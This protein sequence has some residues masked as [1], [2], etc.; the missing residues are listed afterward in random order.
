MKLN[1]LILLACLL[2]SVEGIGQVYTDKVVGKKNEEVRDSLKASEYPYTLP[3]WGKKVTKLGYDL[4]YSA[5]INL[6]YFWQESEL[7]LNN[8]NVGFNNGPMY[9]VDEIIRFNKSTA[10]A[11]AINIR[12][13]IWLFPFLNVYAILGKAKTST[14]INAGVWVPGADNSWSE[15]TSFSTKANFDA[16]MFGIGMTPTFGVGGGFIAIDMNMAWTDVSALD[17]PVFTTVIGPRLG[18]S[19]KFK[20][21]ERNI[22]VWVGG[23]R[24]SFSSD[25]KGSINLSEVVPIDGLQAKVDAGIDKVENKQIEVDNWWGSLSSAEQKNPVNIAKYNTANRALGA[26][27]NFFNSMDAALN[28]GNEAT[29][30][31]SLEKNLKQKWNFIVGSQFQ[32]NKHFMLRMEYGF[33]GARTQFLTGIQYRFGL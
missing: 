29:V 31:Y 21:P 28:D 14:E 15:V 30:Q 11:N 25:T 8:L 10:A 18:K 6:N 27:G 4:P 20:K 32:L 33:L 3:I 7:I 17:K 26:A 24:V 22:A 23:F 2:L 13:D 16:T 5:G 19:F 12:P 9:N 1:P